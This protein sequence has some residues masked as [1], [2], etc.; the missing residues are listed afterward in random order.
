M[1]IKVRA[2]RLGVAG[3]VGVGIG[4]LAYAT[5]VM[6]VP[7]V[8]SIQACQADRTGLLRVVTDASE[9]RAAE[10]PLSWNIQG[11]QGPTGSQGPTGPQGPQGPTGPQGPAGAF[12]FAHVFADGTLDILQSAGIFSV[13]RSFVT[14]TTNDACPQCGL[15]LYCFDL[16]FAP[17]FSPRSIMVTV[18]NSLVP[19]PPGN[20]FGTTRGI[21]VPGV[22]ATV[23]QSV[24][25]D[26]G[27]PFH[28]A[29]A[30]NNSD[31]AV[32]IAAGLNGVPFYLEIK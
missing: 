1:A 2:L 6:A 21:A 15:P 29:D 31:A 10:T 20:L 14:G 32:T 27:C 17:T 16:A 28:G 19:L 26:W 11:P 13:T 3:A 5:S 25:V 22:N 18:E 8:T 4:C 30:G 9:C 7:P 23:Q 24:A 12:A